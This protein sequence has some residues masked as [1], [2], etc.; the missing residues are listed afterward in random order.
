MATNSRDSTARLAPGDTDEGRGQ[1]DTRE[2]FEVT[3]GRGDASSS[4]PAFDPDLSVEL[5]A[6]DSDREVLHGA[7]RTIMRRARKRPAIGAWFLAG[8]RLLDK[9]DRARRSILTEAGL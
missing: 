4:S 5:D 8:H 7:L 2:L 6:L 1:G 3:N 9:I